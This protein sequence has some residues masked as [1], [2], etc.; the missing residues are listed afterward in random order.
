MDINKLL[1]D[2]EDGNVPKLAANELLD[3]N[4]EKI[5]ADAYAKRLNKLFRQLEM[6]KN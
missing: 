2:F 1:L 6:K 3:L 4:R 5:R